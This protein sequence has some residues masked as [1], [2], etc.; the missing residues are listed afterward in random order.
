MQKTLG[1][2][3][4]YIADKHDSGKLPTDSATLSF[5]KRLLNDGQRFC[6]DRLGIEKQTNITTAAEVATLPTDFLSVVSLVRPGSGEALQRINVSQSQNATADFY[7]ITGDIVNGYT[8]HVPS[9][10]TFVLTYVYSPAEMSATSDVC[11]IEDPLAVACYAYAKLRQSETDPIQDA[12][13]HLN[14]ATARL[15]E[16]IHRRVDNSGGYGFTIL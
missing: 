13:A 5:W 15:N 16:V 2:L 7:W 14:E 10:E 4:Q 8:L 1:D 11:V 6:A 12:Q 9:D 3:Y